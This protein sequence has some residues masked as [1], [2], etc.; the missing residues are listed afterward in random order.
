MNTY[1]LGFYFAFLAVIFSLI[2]CLTPK[3]RAEVYGRGQQDNKQSEQLKLDD[4]NT[5]ANAGL[6]TDHEPP[7]AAPTTVVTTNTIAPIPGLRGS[8]DGFDTELVDCGAAE[9]QHLKGK[10]LASLRSM[11]FKQQIR[12]NLPGRDVAEDFKPMR[13]NF[14]VT[15]EG[16]IG[17]LWCG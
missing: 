1:K 16:V 4:E 12:I 9:V 15:A 10:G 7:K 17:K 11:K 14:D 2:G 3:E 5:K 8:E 13:L 6:Q